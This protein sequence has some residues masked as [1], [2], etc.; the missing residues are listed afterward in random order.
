MQQVGVGGAILGGG[1]SFFSNMY[2]WA[3]DNVA[4][5]EVVTACGSIVTASP[6]SY[7]D[8]YWALR[9]GGNNFGIVTKFTLY[10]YAQGKMYYSNF[11]FNNTVLDSVIRAFVGVGINPS[12]DPNGQQILQL[13]WDNG[14]RVALGQLQYAQEVEYPSMF[15]EYRSIPKYL[16]VANISSQADLVATW[17]RNT[18]RGLRQGFW[19]ATYKLDTEFTSFVKDVFYEDG[20]VIENLPGVSMYATLQVITTQ[21]IQHMSRHGGNP[22]GL[23]IE[24]GPLLNF[25][26]VPQWDDPAYD[27]LIH[28]TIA[29]IFKRLN[30]QA[31]KKGLSHNLVYMN[32]ASEYQDVIASYGPEN[33]AN[34]KKIAKKYDP[35]EVFQKLQPG[36]FKLEGAPKA[37]LL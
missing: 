34:L 31:K 35:K 17:G 27:S 16:S 20:K 12:H 4:S 5:F 11:G 29:K 13:R 9:G 18:I 2:G 7:P 33:K 21:Q 8:L 1:I 10:T 37:P 6:N 22:L 24:D 14:N 15:L 23:R 19:T 32:Y 25:L 36:F 26:T 30:E 3:C 28:S